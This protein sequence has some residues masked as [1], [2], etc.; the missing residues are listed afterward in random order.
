MALS[1]GLVKKDN[2]LDNDSET[3]TVDLED[4]SHFGVDDDDGTPQVIPVQPVQADKVFHSIPAEPI[5]E[6]VAV[7]SAFE[8]VNDATFAPGNGDELQSVISTADS[9]EDEDNGSYIEVVDFPT[10]TLA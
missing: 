1:S 7:V 4:F 8:P 10:P 5:A 3:K 6:S 9:D 2:L